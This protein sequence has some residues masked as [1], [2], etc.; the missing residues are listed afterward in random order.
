MEK[1]C[2]HLRFFSDPRGRSDAVPLTPAQQRRVE[3]IDA[4]NAFADLTKYH[5]QSGVRIT[6]KMGAWAMQGEQYEKAAYLLGKATPRTSSLKDCHKRKVMKKWKLKLNGLGLENLPNGFESFNYFHLMDL[7]DN[8]L[9]RIPMALADMEYFSGFTRISPAIGRIQ[10]N[11]AGNPLH[12]MT[13]Q[14]LATLDDT[15]SRPYGPEFTLPDFVRL[16]DGKVFESAASRARRAQEQADRLAREA[17]QR[18]RASSSQQ[19]SPLSKSIQKALAIGPQATKDEIL[20]Q[21]H[22]LSLKYHPDKNP[23]DKQAEDRMKAINTAKAEAL[24]VR[25]RDD[26]QK[27]RA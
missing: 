10:I 15:K 26:K 27:A 1:V 4:C 14:E 16:K 24:A 20:K 3:M 5:E 12:E 21:Y 9:A 7:S 25:E 13:L 19:A 2:K 6:A 23:G 18:A 22:K 11:L 8:K 17:R